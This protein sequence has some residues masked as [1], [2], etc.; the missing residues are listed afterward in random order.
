MLPFYGTTDLSPR[1]S[2]GGGQP[3]GEPREVE[4]GADDAVVVV[5]IHADQ[6]LVLQVQNES[7][8]KGNVMQ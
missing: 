6:V 7:F 4:A 5:R 1:G 2:C 8:R 3:E